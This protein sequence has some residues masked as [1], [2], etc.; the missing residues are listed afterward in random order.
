MY[1]N[2]QSTTLKDTFDIERIKALNLNSSVPVIQEML[3]ESNINGS[4][5][6]QMSSLNKI[7]INNVKSVEK[8]YYENP[9]ELPAELIALAKDYEWVYKYAVKS[10]VSSGE[11]NKGSIK[12]NIANTDCAFRIHKRTHVD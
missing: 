9:L 12:I 7:D 4:N 11:R 10:P 3:N 8:V 2:T 1:G 5:Y 6:Q